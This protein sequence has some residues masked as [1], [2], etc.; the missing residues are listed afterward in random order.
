MAE[1]NYTTIHHNSRKELG[2]SMVEYAIADL[3]YNLQNHTRSRLRGWCYAS[4]PT[5]A[6]LL[7]VSRR[8]VFNTIDALVKKEIAERNDKGYLKTTD[9]WYKTAVLRL[10]SAEVALVQELHGGSA[11]VALVDGVNSA[12]IAPNNKIIENKIDNKNP[13]PPKGRDGVSPMKHMGKT[14]KVVPPE[15]NPNARTIANSANSAEINLWENFFEHYKKESGEKRVLASDG[16]KSKFKTRLKLFSV[17]DLKLAVTNAFADS[18]Y[19]G[20]NDT[21]WRANIDYILRSDEIVD[22]LMRLKPRQKG[23]IFDVG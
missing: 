12:T 4:K 13:L 10:S 16:R 20:D 14:Q 3:I 11:E 6:A 18:F 2:L 22:R 17:D 19:S 21:G 1:I 9:K 5:M 7:G 8:T 15:E 23:V